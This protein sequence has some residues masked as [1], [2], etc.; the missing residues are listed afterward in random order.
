MDGGDAGEKLREALAATGDW[1]IGILKRSDT[2]K[3]F[4]L[5]P[6]RRGVDQTRA[7]LNRNRRRA[8]D[9]ETTTA[10]ATAWSICACVLRMTRRTARQTPQDIGF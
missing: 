8:K 9:F 1:T 5:L 7:R 10:S 4:E 3:R 2:A 6:R